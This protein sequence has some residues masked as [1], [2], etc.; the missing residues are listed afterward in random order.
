MNSRPKNL[1]KAYN[2]HATFLFLVSSSCCSCAEMKFL[3][4]QN[5]Q[6]FHRT[7]FIDR[8]NSIDNANESIVVNIY[9]K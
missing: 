2:F 1:M 4:K 7:P 9:G 5:Y 6:L 3:L 8:K